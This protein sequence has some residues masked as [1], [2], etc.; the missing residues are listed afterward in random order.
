MSARQQKKLARQV[1]PI[2]TANTP[3]LRQDDYVS[4]IIGPGRMAAQLSGMLGV[5]NLMRYASGGLYARAVDLPADKAVARGVII[6]G[7][8]DG[9]ISAE[10]DRLGV[11]PLLA[12]CLRWAQVVGAGALVVLS[13]DS[14]SLADELNEANL[15]NIVEIRAFAGSDFQAEPERY[16]DPMSPKFGTPMRYRV[17]VDG[18]A[19]VVHESRVIPVTGGPLPRGANR[20]PIPWMGREEVGK[21]YRAICRYEQ[22]L[23]YGENILMRKQQGVYSMS[24]LAD[25]LKNPAFNGNPSAG[26]QIIRARINNVDAVRGVLNTVAVDGDDSYT[27]IDNNLGGIKDVIGEM[28]SDVA[29]QFGEPVTLLFGE[30]PGGQNSTGESDMEIW[31][32]KCEGMQKRLNKPLERIVSLIMLQD[33]VTPLED[34]KVVWP[35][36]ESPNEK[37]QAEADSKRATTRKTEV[38]AVAA[39]VNVGIMTD[40]QA[41]EALV[42]LGVYQIAG[43]EADASRGAA[44]DYAKQTA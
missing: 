28:K 17:S 31:H 21:G 7:D 38:E 43:L 13:D 35:P 24:G 26:E 12:D 23:D 20:T 5:S 36:L 10:F 29:A 9:E 8:K 2:E 3:V 25:L 39:A 40:R 18:M 37:E 1:A 41:A 32:E 33:E 11:M 14:N 42:A 34:W 16:D 22:S 6:E 27:V 44:V 19:F 4:A 15:S 30:S